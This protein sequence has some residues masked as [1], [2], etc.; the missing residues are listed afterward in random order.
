MRSTRSRSRKVLTIGAEPSSAAQQGDI[1]EGQGSRGTQLANEEAI[2]RMTEFVSENPN[3]FEE[4][5]R[6]FKG[7]GKQKT[8][9][10]K[11]K[12]NESPEL[13]SDEESERRPSIRST[14]KRV[15]SK[16]TSR[17]ASIFKSFSG[18]GG[19]MGKRVE[20]ESRHPA[21]AEVDYMRAPPFTDNIN[22]ERP[23]LNFKL[24]TIPSYDGDPKYH[25]HAF[26]LAFRLYCIPDLVIC[27]VFRYSS[28][29]LLENGSGIWNL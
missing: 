3:I 2:A 1:P 25:I 5:G 10:S 22:E 17:I 7:Q 29:G 19:L 21:R 13:P 24:P 16:I 4:F 9:F 27:Q 23:L 26:I 28:R 20:E 18:G 12:S 15:S 11:K 8:E 14:L 6:Y